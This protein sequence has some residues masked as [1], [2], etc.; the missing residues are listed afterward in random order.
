MFI[1]FYVVEEFLNNN[2]LSEVNDV[3]F[4]GF[5]GGFWGIDD[6]FDRLV[7]VNCKVG[8]YGNVV[9]IFCFME[10]GGCMFIIFY[11]NCLLMV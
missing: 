1:F 3:F 6:L 4:E 8:D 2:Y 7:E 9:S 5:E 10:Y 11:Y